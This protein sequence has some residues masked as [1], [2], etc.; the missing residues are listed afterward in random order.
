MMDTG[1]AIQNLWTV[2]LEKVILYAIKTG[3]AEH[4]GKVSVVFP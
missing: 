1:K 4:Q 3:T 2:I